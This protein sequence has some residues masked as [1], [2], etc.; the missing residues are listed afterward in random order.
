MWEWT[1]DEK[2]FTTA[3]LNQR[4][5]VQGFGKGTVLEFHKQTFGASGHTINFDAGGE[6]EV[7]LR[8]KGNSETPWL[9]PP[10]TSDTRLIWTANGGKAATTRAYTRG[11]RSTGVESAQQSLNS[12]K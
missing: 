8:R 7:K 6:V 5:Y 11:A 2:V 12:E 3:V 10:M 1:G 4:V 9:L